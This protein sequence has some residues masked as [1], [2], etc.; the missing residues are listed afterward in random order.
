M[1]LFLIGYLG[2]FVK[3]LMHGFKTKYSDEYSQTNK[4]RRIIKTIKIDTEN[5]I[6]GYMLILII[7]IAIIYVAF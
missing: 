4:S 3:W 1:N 2:A 7:L 6:I 5:M